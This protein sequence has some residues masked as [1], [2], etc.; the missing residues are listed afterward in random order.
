MNAPMNLCPEPN[1][2]TRQTPLRHGLR[3]LQA[4]H[5]S[6]SLSEKCTMG[7][8]STLLCEAGPFTMQTLAAPDAHMTRFVA[9]EPKCLQDGQTRRQL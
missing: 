4:A 5:S 6:L 2:L 1:A 8:W 9:R 7:P 3:V